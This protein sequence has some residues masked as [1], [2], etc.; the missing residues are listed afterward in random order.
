M[1]AKR[2]Y[3]WDEKLNIYFEDGRFLH[4]VPVL[5][6]VAAHCCDPDQYDA[7][8]MVLYM[9]DQGAAQGLHT[10]QPILKNVNLEY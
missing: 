10:A 9:P 4:Q 1:V 7:A 2:R 6:G 5:G 8:K 3:L